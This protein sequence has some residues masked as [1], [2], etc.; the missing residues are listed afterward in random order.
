MF[1]GTL[2]QIQD[3]YSQI[4]NRRQGEETWAICAAAKLYS[5]ARQRCL[6][7]RFWSALFGQDRSLMDLDD[8]RAASVLRASYDQG[9]RSVPIKR[10]RGSE[11]RC[12]EFDVGFRPLRFH[13]KERWLRIATA[14][15]M[16][17]P[18]PPVD[19]VLVKDRY[20]VVDGHHRISVARALGQTEID[21]EVTVCEF[22]GLLPWERPAAA[23]QMIQQPV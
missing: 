2:Y 19:L 20:F 15:L 10:I 4:R 18:L 11:S 3:V 8:V 16:R 22:A 17:V 1:D 14:R 6:W 13:S 5:R 23:Q 7:A 21:A 12:G 9:V